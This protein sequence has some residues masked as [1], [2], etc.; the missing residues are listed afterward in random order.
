MCKEYRERSYSLIPVLRGRDW[1]FELI[2]SLD[3]RVLNGGFDGIIYQGAHV[4]G[5]EP[6]GD[7]W[8]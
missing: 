2:T 5:G 1:P 7:G 6:P 8:Y 3:D 4:V